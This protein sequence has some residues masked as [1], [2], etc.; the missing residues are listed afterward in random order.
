MPMCP[1]CVTCVTVLLTG[2]VRA[3]LAVRIIAGWL[4]KS[5]QCKTSQDYSYHLFSGYAVLI[6]TVTDSLLEPWVLKL[7]LWLLRTP[8]TMKQRCI[9]PDSWIT[10]LARSTRSCSPW[11]MGILVRTTS[12]PSHS[13]SWW[14]IPMTMFLSSQS[15]PLLWLSKNT[16][17]QAWLLSS[18]PQMR[19]AA[20]LDR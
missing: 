13:S 7:P 16:S 5:K 2:Q 14:R 12:S 8:V 4:V 3:G 1:D 19:I 17:S 20:L 6:L 9:L 15:C 18:E 11:Q 10:R